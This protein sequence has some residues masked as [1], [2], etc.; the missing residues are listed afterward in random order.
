M[1]L[2][3]PAGRDKG[4]LGSAREGWL[5]IADLSLHNHVALRKSLLCVALLDLVKWRVV[6]LKP[7]SRRQAVV[8]VDIA[9]GLN[10]ILLAVHLG[11]SVLDGILHVVNRR[12]LLILYLDALQSRLGDVIGSGADHGY[13]V[14]HA[15]QMMVENRTA[16]RDS[17]LPRRSIFIGHH[18]LYPGHGLRCGHID[19]ANLRMGVGGT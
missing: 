11:S 13:S 14:S 6:P 9:L 8:V 4:G 5:I 16:G 19:G 18:G 2:I 12:K 3:L 1:A 15:A 7:A 17:A 10:L